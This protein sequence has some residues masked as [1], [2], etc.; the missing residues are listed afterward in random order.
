M[1][2]FG[3][4]RQGRVPRRRLRLLAVAMAGLLLTAC[5]SGSDP[6]GRGSTQGG[7]GS[8]KVA[9]IGSFECTQLPRAEPAGP[10]PAW[11]DSDPTEL[12]TQTRRL[13]FGATAH[14]EPGL[15]IT[16]SK[17]K[18][19][20]PTAEQR[21]EARKVLGSSSQ[22]GK[23][24]P[25]YVAFEV[26]LTNRTGGG[27]PA[28][29]AYG[30]PWSRLI[31]GDASDAETG[32]TLS[33]V[34]AGL[35][36]DGERIT[37]THQVAV[38]DPTSLQYQLEPLGLAERT[39]ATQGDADEAWVAGEPEEGDGPS[40][41][42]EFGD[43]VALGEVKVSVTQPSTFT[44][45]GAAAVTAPTYLRSLVTI[46]NTSRVD[47]VL[48]SDFQVLVGAGGQTCPAVP[49]ADR[50][51]GQTDSLAIAPGRTGQVWVTVAAAGDKD[52]RVHV[53][54]SGDDVDTATAL[55][56][57]TSQAPPHPAET[58]SGGVLADAV[59]I[60]TGSRGTAAFGTPMSWADSTQVVIGTPRPVEATD[61]LREA[62]PHDAVP[63]GWT[64][65]AVPFTARGVH[66]ESVAENARV[67]VTADDRMGLTHLT[68]V[69]RDAERRGAGYHWT[70]TALV[71]DRSDLTVGL[72]APD[73]VPVWAMA[74]PSGGAIALAEPPADDEA[75]VETDWGTAHHY[76]DDVS[77]T[78][79][80]PARP[81]GDGDQ[82]WSTGRL[83]VA[84]GSDKAVPIAIE[85]HALTGGQVVAVNH[86]VGA[87]Q[88]LGPLV[89]TVLPPGANRQVDYTVPAGTDAVAVQISPFRA[90]LIVRD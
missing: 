63:R 49:L 78:V 80:E 17:P 26:T 67:S 7:G 64:A 38:L 10:A 48:L 9:P 21:A 90:P 24:K 61:E 11:R 55:F 44:P 29:T 22:L 71:P 75:L 73:R 68:P 5:D 56:A 47:P 15:T 84:N 86:P 43:E 2:D 76:G 37:V 74:D 36:A 79:T 82:D 4:H 59:P 70:E 32:V 50:G 8:S 77:V 52:V 72:T 45:E 58:P 57:G 3:V 66:A 1:Y 13:A 85:L 19:F 60:A 54:H 28:S 62:F 81:K 51:F 33:E 34:P 16:V 42:A 40:P 27:I 18:P 31:L 39:F 69:G 23:K 88:S 25:G 20:K 6:D 89:Y 35:L 41:Q 53:M 87:W 83:T 65:V 12:G 14:W 46:K 30:E